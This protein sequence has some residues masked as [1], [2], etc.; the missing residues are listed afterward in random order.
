MS[1][2]IP[3]TTFNKSA[4]AT[5]YVNLNKAAGMAGGMNPFPTAPF[6]SKIPEHQQYKEESDNQIIRLNQAWAPNKQ[7]MLDQQVAWYELPRPRRQA[8]LIPQDLVQQR[9]L[10]SPLAVNGVERSNTVYDVNLLLTGAYCR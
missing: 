6:E 10:A 4:T 2:V 7:F 1:V 9:F 8:Y 5:P 3:Q